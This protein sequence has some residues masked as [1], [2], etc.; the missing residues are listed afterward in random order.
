MITDI[1]QRSSRRF[2]LAVISLLAVFI[3]VAALQSRPAAHAVL[4]AK[5]IERK[6]E[7]CQGPETKGEV[8]HL[9]L[10]NAEIKAVISSADY[11][12]AFSS[13]GGNLL[14]L[15]RTAENYDGFTHFYTLLST[16][17][18]NQAHYTNVEVAKDGRDGRMAVV[19][20][21]G[22]DLEAPR[23]KVV[24]EYQL[25]PRDRFL[26]IVSTVTN[27][28]EGT[29]EGYAVGDAVQWGVADNFAP[30][31]GYE[32][33]NVNKAFPWVAAQ[34][35]RISYAYAIDADSFESMNHSTWTDSYIR[36]ITLR[37]HQAYVFRRFLSV[38]TGGVASAVEVLLSRTHAALGT[39]DGYLRQK[40]TNAAI[41]KATV[42]LGTEAMAPFL[43]AI[44]DSE[45][46]YVA[47][48]PPGAYDVSA[49][50]PGRPAS[51]P[52]KVIVEPG[53]TTSADFGIGARGVV[54]YEVRDAESGALLPAKLVVESREGPNPYLGSPDKAEG[55]LNNV[56][57]ATGRGVIGLPPGL[58]R[59]A[60]THGLAYSVAWGEVKIDGG[61]EAMLRL[62]L[63]REVSAPGWFTADFH[64]HADPSDD[65]TVTL[66]DRVTSLAAEGI[67]IVASTDHNIISDYS[68]TIRRLG[69]TSELFSLPG[70]ELTTVKW[71][72]FNVYPL[73]YHPERRW[74]GAMTLREKSPD[75]FFAEARA[76]DEGRDKVIQ[77]NHPRW[78]Y[79]KH[80]YFDSVQLDVAHLE[81]SK[82]RG[83]SLDFDALEIMNGLWSGEDY[84]ATEL[85]LKDWFA[86]LD[87]GYS[88]TAV[89]NS[90]S[91]A[92]ATQEVGY[93]RNY[94]FLGETATVRGMNRPDRRK[95]SEDAVVRAI[96]HHRVVVSN[97]PF[98][99]FTAGAQSSIGDTLTS[100]ASQG[101]VT[102]RIRAQWPEWMG[103]MDT[104]QVFANGTEVKAIPL[105][106]IESPADVTVELSS[107]SD[108]WVIV[109]VRGRRPMDP[110]L[111]SWKG[112]ANTPFAVTNPIWIDRDGNG[113]FDP[114]AGRP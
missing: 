25:G 114:P 43:T 48:V 45:G 112:R 4:I 51:E 49:T 29:V 59:I 3:I 70:D 110:V 18:P 31:A 37:P 52:K 62:A 20:A 109:A 14:D 32:L 94:V 10:M 82:A 74:G 83:L 46:H 36:N 87:R 38:G 56:F 100:P 86:L 1:R 93:P 72:H 5:R 97:G 76:Q 95:T 42:I 16:Y 88:F 39:V 91:H 81:E 50:A 69:L 101:D 7:L 12:Y 63:R 75:A 13:S 55:A 8:G 19:R 103:A 89:G 84:F 85:I 102:L 21:T 105:A 104:L 15:A 27:E 108:A 99:A 98:V 61:A 78:P 47:R 28:S 68:S 6:A 41:G 53:R 58:Y 111:P 57:T 73:E 80:A 9:L 24:T 22:H 60:A 23:I 67:Q 17:W 107:A 65:S 2:A 44:S 34:G 71:G 64:V 11:A 30:G 66:R 92:V 33:L 90:D 96:K 113:K 79:Q 35:E 77:V 106:G 26:T 40:G 54:R